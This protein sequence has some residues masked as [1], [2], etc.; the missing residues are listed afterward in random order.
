MRHLATTHV[1]RAG[2]GHPTFPLYHQPYEPLEGQLCALQ[3][4]LLRAARAFLDPGLQT[5]SITKEEL[6]RVMRSLGQFARGE[7]LQEMLQEVD[8]D[9]KY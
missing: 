1:V 7:E 3:N 4:R 5:G 8:S 9:G 2:G 6:D